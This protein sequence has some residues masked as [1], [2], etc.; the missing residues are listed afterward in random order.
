MN[1]TIHRADKRHLNDI[2]R[3]IVE[4]KIGE[5]MDKFNGPF[6]FVRIDGRIVACAGLEFIYNKKAAVLTHLA[7][8]KRLRR[9]GIGFTLIQHRINVAQK[10][11]VKILALATMYY[12]FNFYK[13]RGFRTCPRKNLPDV[14]KD[15]WMFT[16]PRY[17]KCAVMIQEIEEN[18]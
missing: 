1:F 11:G 4:A 16:V 12:L 17:K 18:K 10:Q 13:K 8:E 7:V 9:H 5:P 3:L 14:V 15:Y 6:W 2:N